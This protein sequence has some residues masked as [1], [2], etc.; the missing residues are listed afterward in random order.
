M[1]SVSIILIVYIRE[2]SHF[3]NPSK[4]VLVFPPSLPLASKAWKVLKIKLVS[5]HAYRWQ[6]LVPG[7]AIIFFL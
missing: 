7:L 4:S 1:M 3:Q 2:K 6:Y 5:S